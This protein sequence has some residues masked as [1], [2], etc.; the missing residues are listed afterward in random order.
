MKAVRDAGKMSGY[1]R[2][3]FMRNAYKEHGVIDIAAHPG[4]GARDPYVFEKAGAGHGASDFWGVPDGN[5]SYSVV[6]NSLKG[7]SPTNSSA[8]RGIFDTNDVGG[9][10][11]TFY[12]KDFKDLQVPA[13]VN[14]VSKA[15]RAY[16]D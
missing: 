15:F 12:T 1:E 6:P 13:A 4:A 3:Q 16:K 5:G 9:H 7:F 11:A 8:S 10:G 2:N 14:L